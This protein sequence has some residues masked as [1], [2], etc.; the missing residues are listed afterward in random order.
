MSLTPTPSGDTNATDL[1]R[2][3][4]KIYRNMKFRQTDPMTGSEPNSLGMTERQQYQRKLT[5]SYIVRLAGLGRK[6]RP[7]LLFHRPKAVF[8]DKTPAK[9]CPMNVNRGG[10][11]DD[12][13][14]VINRSV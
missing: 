14:T 2:K 13:V 5:N 11:G 8:L 12:F 1:N 3:Q 6:R 9:Q 10:G 7:D 4:N